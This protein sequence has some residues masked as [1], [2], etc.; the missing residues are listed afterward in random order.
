MNPQTTSPALSADAIINSIQNLLWRAGPYDAW[1]IGVAQDVVNA[2]STRDTSGLW[3]DRLADTEAD[4][5]CVLA[6]FT[7]LGMTLDAASDET[8]NCVYIF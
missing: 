8:G 4:A 3:N 6:H 7:R 5:R 2:C 1:T